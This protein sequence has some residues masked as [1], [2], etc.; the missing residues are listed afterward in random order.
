MR[1][2]ELARARRVIAVELQGHGHTRDID[3]P[4]D[5]GSFGEDIAAL[6]RYLELGEADLFG[7]SLGGGVCLR[8]TIQHPE[9]VRRLAILSAPMRRDGWLPDVLEAMRTNDSANAEMFKQG[10]MYAAWAAVAPELDA[11]PTLMDKTGALLATPYDWTDEVKQITAPTMLLFTDA[12][13]IGIAHIAEFFTLLG[14]GQADGSWDGSAPTAMRLAVLP[15]RT[16]YNGHQAPE[17]STYL[18]RFFA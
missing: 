6:I 8:A 4:F 10:P 1:L 3:R 2:R 16:H 7:H 12:D 13:S 15:N 18:D 17:L 11:F 5:F 9:L 14:G